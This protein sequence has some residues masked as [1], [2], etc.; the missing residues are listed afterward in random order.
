MII[1]MKTMTK[2]VMNNYKHKICKTKTTKITMTRKVVNNC[3]QE[4]RED[5]DQNG[6]KRCKN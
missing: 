6:C 4:G 2:K 3:S 1:N 5:L